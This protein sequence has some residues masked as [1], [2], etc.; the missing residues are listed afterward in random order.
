MGRLATIISY[1]ANKVNRVRVAL[2]SVEEI[3]SQMVTPAGYESVPL[4]GDKAFMVEGR[5]TGE[6]FHTGVLS[7]KNSLK[8][9]E[10]RIFARNSGGV[11]VASVTVFNDGSALV[12]NKNADIAITPDGGVILT[13]RNGGVTVQP[14]GAIEANGATITL[15]GDVV[16]AAGISL[17]NHGHGGVTTGT[18]ISGQSVIIPGA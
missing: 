9:G 7:R 16:T 13:N 5:K 2:G 4:K 14:D 1:L 6:Y 17:N 10:S 8:D 15:D 18:G 3:T 12:G 11:V